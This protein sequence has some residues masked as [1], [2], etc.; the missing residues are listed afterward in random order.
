MS[1]VNMFNTGLC[2]SIC[3]SNKATK[4][5]NHEISAASMPCMFN[6]WDILQLI[7]YGFYDWTLTQ[8]NF[9]HHIH[10]FVLHIFLNAGN[11]SDTIVE[12]KLEQFLLYVTFISNILPKSLAA[13]LGTGTLSST[14]PGVTKAFN[15]LPLS[16][17]IKCSLN[18]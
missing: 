18:P 7:I 16:L 11:K 4:K 12:Q 13:I 6:L 15:N 2:F 10:N 14:L 5:I 9:I 3:I 8:Q 17:T 1:W